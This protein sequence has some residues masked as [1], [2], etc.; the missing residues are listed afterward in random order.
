VS[1]ALAVV[2]VSEGEMADSPVISHPLASLNITTVLS[3]S[4][5]ATLVKMSLLMT[6]LHMSLDSVDSV[7]SQV[8]RPT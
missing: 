2:S 1:V 4:K 7:V 5:A 3:T 8:P 6:V